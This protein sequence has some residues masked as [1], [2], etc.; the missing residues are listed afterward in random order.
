MTAYN[1]QSVQLH[2]LSLP[3]DPDTPLSVENATG[4]WVLV[5]VT[6]YNPI[7]GYECNERGGQGWEAQV[8]NVHLN[9]REAAASASAEEPP[10]HGE[11]GAGLRPNPMGPPAKR[12][13]K[14]PERLHED[15]RLWRA[16]DSE[17][18]R[19][20]DNEAEAEVR[21][22]YARTEDGNQWKNH[23]LPLSLLEPL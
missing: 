4:R 3:S 13:R 6:V 21:Y 17:R 19:Y 1:A 7:D 2:G 14:E 5:P 20:T 18:L 10:E 23:W 22:L 9:R 8:V 16:H 15:T 11:S 12:L